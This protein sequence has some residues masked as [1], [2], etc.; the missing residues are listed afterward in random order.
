VLLD[1]RLQRVVRQQ[2]SERFR[3]LVA[4]VE[5]ARAALEDGGEF[6]RVHQAFDRA[7]HHQRAGGQR[8]DDG[9]DLA[10]HGRG[11]GGARGRQR[12]VRDGARE[13]EAE[14]L[15]PAPP[16]GQPREFRQ[17]GAALAF[18]QHR[19]RVA[20]LQAA[21]AEHGLEG[22]QPGRFDGFLQHPVVPLVSHTT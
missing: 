7:V 4:D 15:R 14:D 11:A 12:G 9:S 18:A 17:D 5:D 22:L 16:S 1:Q 3:V 2:A 8:G 10:Q 21:A 20:R 6:A 13:H 19:D